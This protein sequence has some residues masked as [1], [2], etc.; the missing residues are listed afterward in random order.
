[1]AIVTTTNVFDFMG[2][3]SDVRTSYNAA[4][5]II[6]DEVENEFEELTGRKLVTTTYAD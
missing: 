1:M 5:A 6:I 4:L 2:T 3:E